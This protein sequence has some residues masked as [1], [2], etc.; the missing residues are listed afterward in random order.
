MEAYIERFDNYLAAIKNASLHTRRSYRSDLYDFFAFLKENEKSIWNNG[1]IDLNA[2]TPLTVR[3]YLAYLYQKNA[4]S[5][6][7]RKLAAL[8]SFFK[9]MVK[10]G[11]VG[12][13]PAHPVSTPRKELNIPTFLSVDEMFSLIEQPDDKKVLGMRDRA[14]LEL[15]Y[16]CGLRVSEIVGLNLG[17]VDLDG[18]FVNVQ[19]KGGKERMVPMGSKAGEALRAYLEMRSDLI[20]EPDKEVAQAIFLNNRGGR[21]TARSI[22]RMIERYASRLSVFRPVHPHA[23]RHTFATHLLDAGADLRAIQELL[24]HSSLSTTQKYTHMGID[25]L[26]EVYD[27]AHPRA[28]RQK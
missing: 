16:S 25:R 4:K 14:I 23:I 7:A 9:F 15:L 27:E 12:S 19:G 13:H 1:D 18:G 2:V 11:L 21:L 8:K 28:K 26:M 5:T 3:D 6:I 24:G 17:N 10:E 22:G 20:R